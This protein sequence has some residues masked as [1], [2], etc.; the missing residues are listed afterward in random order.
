METTQ[1]FLH[2]Q[3][4]TGW[5]FQ[6]CSNLGKSSQRWVKTKNRSESTENVFHLQRIVGP[7]F[8][9]KFPEMRRLSMLYGTLETYLTPQ[10]CLGHRTSRIPASERKQCLHKRLNVMPNKKRSSAVEQR[11]IPARKL[12]SLDSVFSRRGTGERV[13]VDGCCMI[14]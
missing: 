3:Y 10:T 8:Q 12:R 7:N 2:H 5:W 14:A 13:G 1:Q 6:L 9:L 11:P 4:E